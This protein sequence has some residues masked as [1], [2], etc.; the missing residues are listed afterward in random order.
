M[1]EPMANYLAS[2]ITGD[3]EE[4][5][6]PTV[7]GV[8]YSSW[9]P[10]GLDRGLLDD[11]QAAVEAL[12]EK[13]GAF[14][15]STYGTVVYTED[16]AT[17]SPETRAFIGGVALEVQGRSL[18]SGRALIGR[19]YVHETAHQWMGDNVSLTD[20]SH[21]LW[22]IEGFA[23]FAE[24]AVAVGDRP[25]TAADF[26]TS[27]EGCGNE[28]AGD[29]PRGELFSNRSYA[30]GALVFYALAKEVGEKVF[31]SILREFNDRFRH[32]NARTEDLVAVASE[33]SGRD[34]GPFFQTWLYSPDR[35]PMP[36]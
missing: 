10:T 18:Y 16:F 1:D 11:G 17:G 6:G 15:F 9:V 8:T 21:D 20:W 34:L 14:P 23:R 26:A 24:V 31:W 30:C 7:D 25:L 3:L 33:L 13:L 29:I 4:I 32:A 5:Q 27:V 19:T 28:T 22:W 36:E 2:V 35:P 12:T